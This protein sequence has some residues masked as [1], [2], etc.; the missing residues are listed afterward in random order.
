VHDG[1]ADL[2]AEHDIA[3]QRDDS[4]AGIV[5]RSE[6][7]RTLALPVSVTENGAV[8][9]ARSVAVAARKQ[10]SKRTPRTTLRERRERLAFVPLFRRC[11]AREIA[12]I[13]AVVT[14]RTYAEGDVLC[15]EGEEG[16]EFYIVV[17]GRA[18]VTR[19]GAQLAELHPG[20]FFGEMAMLDGGP[21]TST[22]IA[23][24]DLCALALD[25]KRFHQVLVKSPGVAQKIM[26]E[27]ARR[28][29]SVEGELLR[30]RDAVGREVDS[31]CW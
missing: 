27:L 23:S 18:T 5:S 24:T 11:S 20:S 14:E 28:L 13:A 29:R 9:G 3:Q 21:R 16:E 7:R 17:A 26:L 12:A 22:V 8:P 31:M 19:R 15:R 1:L 30:V 4:H 25:R 6:G 10:G 2:A